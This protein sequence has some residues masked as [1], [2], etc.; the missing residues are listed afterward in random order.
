MSTPRTDAFWK[1]C[2]ENNHTEEDWLDFASTLERELAEAQRRFAKAET[3]A[4]TERSAESLDA[5]RYRYLRNIAGQI[6]EDDDGPM[7]CDGLGD[8]FE[9]LRGVEVDASVD[10]AMDRWKAAGSPTPLPE[11]PKT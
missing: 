11:A 6:A 4:L 1:W 9:F 5:E 8:N 3:F 10:A 7:V 2:D